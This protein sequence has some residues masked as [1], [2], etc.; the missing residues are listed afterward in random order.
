[1]KSTLATLFFLLPILMGAAYD[2]NAPS[3]TDGYQNAITENTEF[4]SDTLVNKNW[5]QEVHSH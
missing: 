1:M 3:P 2:Q 4:M 5:S